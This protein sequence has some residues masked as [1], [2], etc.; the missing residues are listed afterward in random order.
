MAP[1][2]RTCVPS[3]LP[4]ESVLREPDGDALP[5]PLPLPLRPLSRLSTLRRKLSVEGDAGTPLLL[6]LLLK[7]PSRSRRRAA[8]SRA[9][10]RSCWRRR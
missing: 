10:S 2:P 1:S 4:V 5:L 3:T 7:K 6:L 8:A 9:R